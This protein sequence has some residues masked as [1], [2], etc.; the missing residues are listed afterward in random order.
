MSWIDELMGKTAR[1]ISKAYNDALEAAVKKSREF[2]RRAR[3]VEK[4]KIKPPSSMKTEKQKEAW[5]RGYMRRAAEKSGVVEKIAQEMQ[6][7]GIKA[8]KRIEASMARVYEKSRANV[9]KLL[10]KAAPSNLPTL[11]RKE[12]ELLLYR[13]GAAGAF[14]RIALNNIGSDARAVKRLRNEFAQALKKGE[15]DA[16]M[17][18]RIRNVTGME[19]RD[20]RRVLRTEKTHI[21][22]LAKQDTAM[23]HYRA[24]GRRSRKRWHCTF[25][26]SRD[27][28]IAMDGQ[29]VW[30]DEDFTLPSGAPISYPGDSRAGA[31][32]VCNCQCW[33]EILE[34]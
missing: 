11:T 34:G 8:R 9:L 23:E 19:E 22:S 6:G 25:R 28:H 30:I 31:A 1:Q 21:E 14:S 24:T 2:L 33:L 27:S 12:I 3:D 20:A 13:D 29:T 26:N 7:A 32:E 17:I 4:G 18:A 5:K 16:Q 15:N 10:D